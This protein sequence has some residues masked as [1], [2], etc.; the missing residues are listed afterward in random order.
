[1]EFFIGLTISNFLYI[2]ILL[3]LAGVTIG[4]LTGNGLFDKVKLAKEQYENAEQK[5]NAILGDYENKVREYIDG[6]RN[7]NNKTLTL[8]KSN[9]T[10]DVSL[11][12]THTEDLST[13]ENYKDINEED[14]LIEIIGYSPARSGTATSSINTAWITKSYNKET[15]I[16]TIVAPKSA[17]INAGLQLNLNLYLYN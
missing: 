15:G 12:A 2:I 17:Y 3:I 1:M 6:T 5:E 7:E 13:F 9:F 16:L 10:M 4:Q 8:I 14:F 11:G